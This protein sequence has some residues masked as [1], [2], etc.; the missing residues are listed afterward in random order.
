MQSIMTEQEFQP[1]N[2]MTQAFNDYPVWQW[3]DRLSR[4]SSELSRVIAG[5]ENEFLE[6]GQGVQDLYYRSRDLS[7]TALELGEK[8]SG[9]ALKEAMEELDSSLKEIQGQS[10]DTNLEKT[11]N[12]CSDLGVA[13]GKLHKEMQHFRP[14]LKHLRVL[15]MSIRIESARM[16]EQ[17]R[18]FV[19]LAQEVE[20]LGYKT[21]EYSRDATERIRGL[22]NEVQSLQV[23]V[24][25]A[26][27]LHSRE[28]TPLLEGVHE[29]SRQLQEMQKS[30]ERLSGSIAGRAESIKEMVG[31]IIS[32]VQFH[33]ITRQQVEHVYQSLDEA[34][35]VFQG[36]Q[37]EEDQVQD[38]IRWL[39][40]VC[41][42][43]SRQLESTRSGLGKA[44][45]SI[46][47]SLGG[48]GEYVQEQ[49]ADMQGF[50]G[51]D[52]GSGQGMLAGLEQD[53]SSLIPILEKS[54]SGF[55]DVIRRLESMSSDLEGMQSLMDT[56]EDI[57][58]EI[59]LIALNASVKSAHTGEGG[60]PLGVLAGAIHRLSGDTKN[61]V[62][63]VSGVLEEILSVAGDFS[64]H[65]EK[66]RAG[67]QNEARLCSILGQVVNRM[68]G[69]NTEVT[70]LN[71]NLREETSKLLKLSTKI[72][73]KL[74][75]QFEVQEEIS[76]IIKDLQE[77]EQQIQE[78]VPPVESGERYSQRLSNI[79]HRYTMESERS[80]Y[81]D[82][83][84]Q[85]QEEQ[86][87]GQEAA[88]A[89]EPELFTD[90]EGE[91]EFG[92]NVELF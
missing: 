26:H 59:A 40:D 39:G 72:Q 91:D 47:Q 28:I 23:S 44:M 70:A 54:T 77:V 55:E 61:V 25:S 29:K 43:Q 33:D 62:A 37:K 41:S 34:R 20:N 53:A 17:G 71:R 10:E 32:S 9:S 92:D 76:A 48:I 75:M 81:R 27:N 73:K 84:G 52:S 1:E 7:A 8:A 18:H 64:S 12:R 42:L 38:M 80:V 36:E 68:S 21:E 31:E 16:G 15:A 90:T 85:G 60:K 69:V 63:S 46:R 86:G 58:E 30:S 19:T 57:G 45:D 35:D 78:H 82:F 74:D 51:L 67:S 66:A 3:L 13:V 56:L 22:Q 83:T 6:I 87:H 50:T 24:N 14:M 79:L 49:E 5:R 4:I 65:A 2:S 88:E 89:H 11:M